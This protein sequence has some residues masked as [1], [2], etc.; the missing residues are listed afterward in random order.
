MVEVGAG[1][2]RLVGEHHAVT[3]RLQKPRFD[4]RSFRALHQKLTRESRS[5]EKR[6]LG[7]RR[8]RPEQACDQI[9]E[10]ACEDPAKAMYFIDQLS[11]TAVI[12]KRRWKLV[13]QRVERMTRLR[14]IMPG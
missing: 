5:G 2:E 10:T 6:G 3:D 11:R 7:L 12:R 13:L 1:M 14:G 8:R 9:P 4:H